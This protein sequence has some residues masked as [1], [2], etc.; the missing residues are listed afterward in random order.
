MGAVQMFKAPKD[1]HRFR[2]GQ[3][4]WVKCMA[5]NHMEIW[6]KWRGKGRYVSGIIDKQNPNVGKIMTL[7]V[8]AEFKERIER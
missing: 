2:K 8:D 6:F 5:A 1:S 7:D 4:V 3:K